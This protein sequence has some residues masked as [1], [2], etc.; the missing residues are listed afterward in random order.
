VYGWQR[1][2]EHARR[3]ALLREARRIH[4]VHPVGV[5]RDDA[6]VV[7]DDDHRDMEI[8]RQLLHQLEDLRLDRD[9]ERGRRLVGDDQLRI[10]REP[11]RD[12]DPLRIPPENW[13]GYWVSLRG[14]S[15]MP[16]IRRSSTARSRACSSRI[17]L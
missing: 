10:A 11:D 5:A 9:V 2:R 4:H 7:R 1:L 8:A 16:T 14:A 12:H 13:C 6:E 17:P 15:E 3:G